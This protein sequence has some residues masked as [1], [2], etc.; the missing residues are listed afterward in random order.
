MKHFWLARAV[1]FAVILIVALGVVG[2]I[3]MYL[4]NW[5]VPALFSGPT[6]TYWQTLG[7]LLL[8]RLLFGGLRP[9]GP[10][11]HGAHHGPFGR[12]MQRMR[13]SGMTHEERKKM[14]EHLRNHRC[15]FGRPP[16]E[17]ETPGPETTL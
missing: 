5:L 11:G 13:W 1:K 3:V 10:F 9:R 17:R 12:Q 4:W 15:G 8:S 2:V 7:L 6:L 14:R 16:P